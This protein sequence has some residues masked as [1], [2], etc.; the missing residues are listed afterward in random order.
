M[1]FL[2]AGGDTLDIQPKGYYLA[3]TLFKDTSNDMKVN[4]E[5]I[6]GPVACVIKARDYDHALEMANDSEFG[7]TAGI[8]T[9]SL[10]RSAHFKRHAKSGCVMV[11]LPTAGTDYHVPFGGRKNSSYGS[12]EQGTYA[13]EFYTVVKTNYSKPY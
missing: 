13:A 9:E 6:F 10:A 7:L 5:E 8:I 4:R 1:L 2:V 12:R 3:P 11:N